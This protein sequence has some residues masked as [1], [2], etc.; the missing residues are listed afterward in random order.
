MNVVV[1]NFLKMYK[2]EKFN[3]KTFHQKFLQYCFTDFF[4]SFTYIKMP[5]LR[6]GN[7]YEIDNNTVF[8]NKI[9]NFRQAGREIFRSVPTMLNA[10]GRQMFELIDHINTV[11]TQDGKKPYP[12]KQFLI[13]FG[14]SCGPD[15]FFF[16]LFFFNN[17]YF[18]DIIAN[19]PGEPDTLFSKAVPFRDAIKDP[20]LDLYASGEYHTKILKIQTIL[21]GFLE[22]RNCF[23]IKSGTEILNIFA[24]SFSNLQFLVQTKRGEKIE[25]NPYYATYL[26]PI[27]Q[28]NPDNIT[29]ESKHLIYGDDMRPTSRTLKDEGFA[30]DHKN[31]ALTAVLFFIGG[32]HYTSAIR[33]NE[34]WWYYDDLT[35]KVKILKN[36][37]DGIFNERPNKKAQLLFYSY[38]DL[39]SIDC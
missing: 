20:L 16:I 18:M 26:E 35:T 2:Y 30:M 33:A 14:N 36:P 3:P 37:E 17:G 32:G 10:Q 12:P 13:N 25:N 24:F 27:E 22:S 6:S 9:Y 19:N 23:D 1:N 5:T 8:Y 29:S 4:K 21:S 34:K 7:T 28:N 15:S 39:D 31:Y 11:E 38:N